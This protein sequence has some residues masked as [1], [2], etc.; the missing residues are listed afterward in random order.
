MLGHFV[1]GLLN[2][3]GLPRLSGFSGKQTRNACAGILVHQLTFTISQSVRH[4]SE[5]IA[6]SK[7]SKETAL[8]AL[9]HD[10]K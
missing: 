9:V 6:G 3:I 1:S 8:D 10:Q 2:L 5:L 4:Q 7:G